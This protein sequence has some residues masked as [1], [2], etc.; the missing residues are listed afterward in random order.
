MPWSRATRHRSCAPQLRKPS[1]QATRAYRHRAGVLPAIV[2]AFRHSDS[3]LGTR[4]NYFRL[5]IVHRSVDRLTGTVTAERKVGRGS[6]L[7]V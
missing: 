2:D 7:M 1:P 6:M 5:H 4:Y 3:S